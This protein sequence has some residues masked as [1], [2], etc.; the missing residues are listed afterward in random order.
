MLEMEAVL[1]TGTVSGAPLPALAFVTETAP[2]PITVLTLA[3]LSGT[4]SVAGPVVARYI[5][6]EVPPV[7]VLDKVA[8]LAGAGLPGPFEVALSVE[9]AVKPLKFAVA[10]CV[11]VGRLA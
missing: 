7:P 8:L 9:V 10:V 1:T 2:P 5:A 4:K 11:C 6:P 3:V